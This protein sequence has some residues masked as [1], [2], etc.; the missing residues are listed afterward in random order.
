MQFL[1][2]PR[3]ES[4]DEIG[5][6]EDFVNSGSLYWTFCHMILLCVMGYLFS[7]L[8]SMMMAFTLPTW[9][10]PHPPCTTLTW[11]IGHSR[12]SLTTRHTWT[13]VCTSITRAITS[14]QCP[15]TS[16][17]LWQTSTS[18]T[19]TQSTGEYQRIAARVRVL[20]PA[21]DTGRLPAMPAFFAANASEL[22][23][24]Q[25]VRCVWCVLRTR[26]RS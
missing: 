21:A 9:A 15:I 13:T 25:V 11:P 10:T 4:R 2:L 19:R 17:A 23:P 26:L 1:R 22:V 8:C 12:T 20:A 6:G 18:G 14:Q 7:D 16:W 24:P 5:R 3:K